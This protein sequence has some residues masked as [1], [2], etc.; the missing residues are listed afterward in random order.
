MLGRTLSHYQILGKLG[1]GGMGVVYLAEDI[2][3]RRRVALKVLPSQMA[4]DPRPL[5]RF[6]LE[7]R[8]VAAL[9]H[10]NIVT[11]YAI[12][13]AE[14]ERFL[15]MELVEGQTLDRV[16]PAGGL[17][18]RELLKLAVPMADAL[19]A[20]HAKGITHRD[21]KPGNIMVT[22]ESRVKVLDFGLAKLF[23][24]DST[25]LQSLP[26]ES[27]TQDGRLVGTLAY[28]APELLQGREPNPRSDVFALGIVLY[29]MAT[30]VSPFPGSN[31][32]DLISAVLRDQPAEIRRL[33]PAVPNVVSEVIDR[34][35]KKV[36]EERFQNAAE[37]RDALELVQ[38]QLTTMQ[39][40]GGRRLPSFPRITRRNALS[41]AGVAAALALAL[42]GWWSWQRQSSLAE[43]G[44]GVD[45][46]GELATAHAAVVVLPLKNRSGEPDF[47]VDGMTDDLISALARLKGM[48]VISR[49][50]A[51]YY[52]DSRALLP[53]IARELGVEF[54]VEGSVEKHGD[55]VR[56]KTSV[57]RASP[58]SLLWS[59]SLEGTHDNPSEL[60]NRFARAVSEAMGV[61]V[62]PS[63]EARLAASREVEPAVYQALLEGRYYANKSGKEDHERAL[64]LFKRVVEADPT[65]A[66]AWAAMANSLIW[67]AAFSTDPQE[68]LPEAQKA[69]QKAVALDEG[70]AEGHAALGEMALDRWDWAEAERELRSAVELNPS[71]A[72][73]RRKYWML[74]ACLRRLPEAR[75]Q[76][77]RAVQLDPVSPP[78]RTS[79]AFHL[80]FENR[81]EEAVIEVNRALEVDPNYAPAFATSWLANH[82]LE[83]EP[84][85]GRQLR[86]YLQGYG[87]GD[88]VEEYDSVLAS[89]GYSA[90]LRTVALR[91]EQQALT[92]KG[93]IGIG[94]GLLS[95]S[96]EEERALRLL[97]LDYERRTWYLQWIAVLPD[98][99]PLHDQPAFRDLVRLM[100]L[101]QP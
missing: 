7:A 16:V 49:Q 1:E 91:L 101:P 97:H 25:Q 29:E 47:F 63:E 96:G 84:E 68:L 24:R 60:H 82:L 66:P 64:A 4:H 70:L 13:E 46:T 35:L 93:P 76:V 51:M 75:E 92:A 85:R 3:L 90:A 41:V 40:L 2:R 54:V 55:R 95:L 53:E 81:Y 44:S 58:E 34:C 61:K 42:I 48:R 31:P 94:A 45:R 83:K 9:N 5:R 89:S 36:P 67:L 79:Y 56:L 65:N 52:K 30:G 20:A 71:S 98:Y 19:A 37:V 21:F 33:K 22:A 77:T 28:M 99:K 26:K 18:S 73:A 78:V 32:A 17:E 27:L 57:V 88:V 8:A 39:V 50:S 59:D 43:S 86:A 62:S 6:E 69:A 12:E 10:P 74:L 23:D 100:G 80:V 14:G 11:L 72:T 38:Q 87:H 15:A